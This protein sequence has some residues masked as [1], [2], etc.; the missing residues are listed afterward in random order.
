MTG[1][2]LS[3]KYIIGGYKNMEE[4]K[5]LFG[6]GSLS[7][8]EFSQ[9]LGEAS[10]TIE[11]ANVKAG[12]YVSRTKYGEIE[13]KMTKLQEKYNALNEN[14]QGYDE[15]KASY[16]DITT[17]YN[18]LLAKQDETEKMSLISGANVNP[19]FAKFVY[20]EVS[21]QVTDDKNFQTALTEYLKENKE[22][23]NAPKSTYTNLQNGIG[24]ALSANEKMNNF[25]RSKLK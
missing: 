17:K 20:S 11:L 4:L 25:I 12:N 15:L 6:E 10:D 22:F 24:E 14:S 1:E 23:V 3:F 7:Y 5:S 13:K 19:R 18:T 16:D 2:R 21:S 8:E 9:K